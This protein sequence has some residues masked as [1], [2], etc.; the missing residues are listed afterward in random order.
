MGKIFIELEITSGSIETVQILVLGYKHDSD[1]LSRNDRDEY[2]RKI[3]QENKSY[4]SC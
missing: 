4:Y 2:F 3:N 1:I